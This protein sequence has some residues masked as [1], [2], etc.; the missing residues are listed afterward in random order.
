MPAPTFS[1]LLMR[2]GKG[3]GWC[4]RLG[5]FSGGLARENRGLLVRV[6]GGCRIVDLII[7][8]DL[9]LPFLD[10]PDLSV[11]VNATV[12]P[13]I[14]CLTCQLH[15]VS[16]TDTLWRV[17]NGSPSGFEDSVLVDYGAWL[18]DRNNYNTFCIKAQ[19]ATREWTV[20]CLVG[21][22]PSNM[23][24]LSPGEVVKCTKSCLG[25][26]DYGG[27]SWLV[28]NLCHVCQDMCGWS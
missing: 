2:K 16:R 20:T 5:P 4:A 6:C 22:R 9:T 21:G 17:N 26:P 14:L 7:N 25:I 8:E 23:V 12:N 28:Y 10:P 15:A 1:L 19:D 11:T 3:R 24:I 18:P 13:T 27:G